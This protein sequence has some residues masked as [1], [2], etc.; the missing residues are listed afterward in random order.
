MKITICIISV[1]LLFEQSFS[2]KLNNDFSYLS[3][4]TYSNKSTLNH[5]NP[6][7]SLLLQG[8]INMYNKPTPSFNIGV[9]VNIIKKLIINIYFEKTIKPFSDEY[10]AINIRNYTYYPN[11]SRSHTDQ[12]PL[13]ANSE[14][15]QNIIGLS[16]LYK[17][18][19]PDNPNNFLLGGGIGYYTGAWESKVDY[20]FSH[21][22]FSFKNT[23]GY[24]I[25]AIYKKPIK[26]NFGFIFEAKYHIVKREIDLKKSDHVTL[27][28]N[29]MGDVTQECHGDICFRTVNYYVDGRVHSRTTYVNVEEIYKNYNN[30]SL[31]IGIYVNI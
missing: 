10:D 22:I 14:I 24:H 3:S 27:E 19:N 11:G 1:L 28:Y 6:N 4:G 26:S 2:M 9:S 15:T 31:Q 8:G 7:L 21:K 25:C 23:I 13:P 16:L 20:D 17:F 30:L 29:A 5:T 18:S 12:G